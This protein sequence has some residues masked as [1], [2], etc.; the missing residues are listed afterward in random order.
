MKEI[1]IIGPTASGKSD[2][3][4]QIALQHNAYILSLDSLSI[5][6]EI[7]I[8]SAKPSQDELAK[9]HHFGINVLSPDKHF[10][11]STFI[12]LYLNASTQASQDGKNLI[13]VGGTGFYLK[14][15]LN[16]LSEIPSI[17]EKTQI[18]STQMM[19]SPKTA[20]E[21]LYN[22]DQDYMQNIKQN[23]TYRIEKMLQLYLETDQTP[24]TWFKEHP[25]KPIIEHLPLFEI[26]VDRQTLRERIH[27]RTAKML[28]LGLINEIAYLEH[29]YTRLPN[30][31]KAIGIVEVLDY[32]DGISTKDEMIDL[33]TTHTSQ[34]AK[35]QQ[36]FNR[37]Q[38]KD[39]RVLSVEM[40]EKE[41]K[42]ILMTL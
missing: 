33:I 40:I 29:K 2:L 28:H 11:V 27:I 6:K 26:D 36:T 10:S 16:G 32:L 1:A 12:D 9:I 13:I 35:R 8:A 37:N 38:F 24:S 23:D 20:Y 30:S 41:V 7:D 34:L 5:Y 15:L 21:L 22:I 31:M 17:S 14:S 19:C 4:L 42:K 3:A 39:K 25:P 18:L